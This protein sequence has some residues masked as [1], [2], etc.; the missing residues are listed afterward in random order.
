VAVSGIAIDS[1]CHF[2]MVCTGLGEDPFANE[3]VV[4]SEKIGVRAL[5]MLREL[6]RLA[7]EGTSKRN[8]IAV[9]ELLTSSD[10]A[11]YCPFAYGYSN[12]ARPRYA[13]SPLR[14]GGL[15]SIS[16]QHRCR[17]TLGGAGVA[18][19]SHCREIDAAVDYSMFVA[20]AS[21]QSGLY[22]DSGGQP[23]HRG[24]WLD[25]RVNAESNDFFSDTLPT[26]DEAWLR[27]RWNGY[28]R[29]QEEAGALVHQYL[30]NGGEAEETLTRMNMLLAHARTVGKQ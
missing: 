15:V 29:F 28:L 12:Y 11:A 19:S 24:A 16:E 26:L 14:F 8:P 18:I 5:G 20:E 27:P 3:T 13:R 22:F 9:W 2:F 21:C 10:E 25:S 17:S 6:M 30:W 7:V 1:L 4:V 23:G